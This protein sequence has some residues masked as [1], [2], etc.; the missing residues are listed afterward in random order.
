MSWIKQRSVSKTKLE[1]L[2]NSRKN[3][4]RRNMANS[5]KNRNSNKGNYANRHSGLKN[6]R[7]PPPVPKGKLG[8]RP[9]S[10]PPA[11]PKKN[12]KKKNNTVRMSKYA[13]RGKGVYLGHNGNKEAPFGNCK[14]KGAGKR[15][16]KRRTKRRRRRRRTRRRRR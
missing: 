11:P 3:N 10:A 8:P 9:T 15:R 16:T 5:R 14:I 6:I 13:C 4:V 1:K 7:P 2:K 12:N